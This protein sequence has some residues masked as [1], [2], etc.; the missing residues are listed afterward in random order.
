M[1]EKETASGLEWWLR[2]ATRR[3]AIGLLAGGLGLVV[4]YHIGLTRKKH[5]SRK[6]PSRAGA[7]SKGV[8][9]VR[10]IEDFVNAQGTNFDF[11]PPVP[12]VVGWAT[13]SDD[14]PLF[15]WVDYAGVADGFQGLELGT[16][17][18][19]T[20]IERR[21]DDGRAEVRVILNTRNALAWVIQLD[22]GGNVLDQIAIKTPI[23]GYRP[24]EAAAPPRPN[25]SLVGSKFE[26]EFINTAPGAPLPDLV[27]AAFALNP[28]P[29]AGF[30]LLAVDFKAHGIGTIRDGN[31][32]GRLEVK[33]VGE[34]LNTPDANFPVEV[35]EVR[36][37]G[38]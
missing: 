37:L 7:E 18:A 11:V 34:E 1:D 16:K 13:P 26:I 32:R 5:R 4:E 31:R 21:L 10:R 9:G 38:H 6:P 15:A 20:V 27:K 22:L 23:F 3:G 35:I 28:D 2:H 33:Q 29:P 12:D 25:P 24:Q 8:A 19:G 30:E 17:T 14:P 36:R